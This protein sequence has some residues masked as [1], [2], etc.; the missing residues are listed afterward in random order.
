MPLTP[1]HPH[2]GGV[3]RRALLRAAAAAFVLA[4]LAIAVA[5][6]AAEAQ[7]VEVLGDACALSAG[8]NTSLSCSPA[9]LTAEGP[10]TIRATW[11]KPAEPG[12]SY[13]LQVILSA[14]PGIAAEHADL[15]YRLADGHEVTAS[16]P[17]PAG[18]DVRIV[19]EASA[20]AAGD[21]L[22]INGLSLTMTPAPPV[23]EPEE[24]PTA[25]PTSTATASPTATPTVTPSPTPTP[26]PTPPPVIGGL[27]NGDF[28][29]TPDLV[30]WTK[31]GGSASAHGGWASLVSTSESTKYLQQSVPVEPGQWYEAAAVLQVSG[32]AD[33]GWVRIA[34]YPS[35][36]GSGSQ[37]STAD[38]EGMTGG[39][40]VVTTGPVQAPPD[41][42]SA[43]VRLMLRPL[44]AAPAE[45][46]ADLAT[47]LPTAPPPLP[48]LTPTPSPTP[49]PT[50]PPT[51]IA[52]PS[53]TA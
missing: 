22:T 50:V 6:P 37:L 24:T 19:V 11:S 27:V 40:A 47:F 7:T 43:T 18:A 4:T 48:T 41:A 17:A 29:A 39:P 28:G 30:G 9:V 26:T 49:T 13:D 15:K 10:G 5:L 53:A 14:S 21:T 35:A 45:L 34:W 23:D 38:S 25:T 52:T 42:R 36:D 16:G 12:A 44:S 32:A 33:A 3:R 2:L 51:P 1:L 8:G 20:E 31:R 46:R